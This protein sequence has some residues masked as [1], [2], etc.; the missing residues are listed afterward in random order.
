MKII[1]LA[2]T[3]DHA[4]AWDQ[5]CQQSLQASLLHTRRFLSYHQQRFVDTS[6][7]L[8]NAEDGAW[9]GV[10]PAALAAPESDLVISHPG[11]TYGGIV[12]QGKL[13]GE[14]MLSA[15]DAISNHYRQLGI[16]RVRYKAVPTIYQQRPAQDDLYALFRIKAERVRCDLS[17][18]INL[19][20]AGTY[21]QQ[22]LRGLK[23]A[24]KSGLQIQSSRQFMTE[25]WQILQHNLAEKHDAKPVHSLAEINLLADRF[26]QQIQLITAHHQGQIVAG[27]LLFNSPACHHAQYIASTAAG[28][29]I[30]ALD[31]V[32]DYAI[33]Q[34]RLAGKDWF[35]FGIS[36]EDNGQYLNQGLYAFKAGFGGSGVVHEFFDWSVI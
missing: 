27:T 31:A 11:A 25:F 23:R 34:A 16:R 22:R 15:F 1:G 3:E 4:A 6:L 36:N 21:H 8:L 30:G 2:Y 14:A 26:P 19:Q 5:F 29:A 24:Q 13:T 20:H 17:C 7:V 18:A 28:R 9:L 33:Q 32:F 12:H 10:F 35:D